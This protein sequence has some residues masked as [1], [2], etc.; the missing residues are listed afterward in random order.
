MKASAYP[1]EDAVSLTSPSLQ[2]WSPELYLEFCSAGDP[3]YEAIRKEHYVVHKGCHGQQIHF[4]VWYKGRIA[5]II[6]GASP[7][8]A[9]PPRDS[10]FKITSENR[11][12]VI[13]GIVDN[14]VFRLV[15]HE[16]NLG[17]RVLA[18]WEKAVSQTWQL[19]Y[20]VEVFGFET[21]IVREGL[22]REVV[23]ADKDK[24]RNEHFP[25]GRA[26]RFVK[27]VI[28]PEGN[29]R[30]GNLY[31]AANWTYAGETVGSTKGHDGVGLT[32]GRLGGKGA[33][34]R[35]VTPLKS[36]YCKWVSGFS[37]PVESEYKS[38][39]KAATAEGTPEE[40]TLAKAKSQARKNLMGRLF[41]IKAGRL[42]SEDF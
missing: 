25:E 4:M 40:K 39:W 2:P 29:I 16:R 11:K 18:L 27:T 41:Y 9:S 6:S 28:D 33:F 19:L 24:L 21:F 36:V 13:N 12:K 5:G 8:Y 15:N 42:A 3:R 10:F 31:K 26:I 37:E 14:V 34:S 22:M 35:R 17:S 1:V 32:G 38:S 30:R 23:T 7:V 20:G